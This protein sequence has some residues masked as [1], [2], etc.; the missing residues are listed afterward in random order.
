ADVTLTSVANGQGV[1]YSTALSKWVNY[2]IPAPGSATLAGDS[3]VSITGPT[4]GQFLVYSTTS[5]KWI[6]STSAIGTLLSAD[7]DVALSGLTD[8]DVL[9]YD[10]SLTKW[11][12]RAT[13]IP[14][15]EASGTPLSLISTINFEGDGTYIAVTNP[16][17]GNVE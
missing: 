9:T 8:G 17:A 5:S 11:V 10:V 14:A 12:N 13:V 7:D 1:K 4:N 6:N 2:T 16:T 15:F 3:D